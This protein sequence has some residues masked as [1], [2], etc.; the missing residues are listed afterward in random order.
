MSAD[1]F[2]DLKNDSMEA[3][4]SIENQEKRPEK[5]SEEVN[6]N[7]DKPRRHHRKSSKESSS[8]SRKR[9]INDTISTLQLGIKRR[10]M[11]LDQNEIVIESFKGPKLED[12]MKLE[13]VK[14]FME[15]NNSHNNAVIHKM[16]Y[17]CELFK[18]RWTQLCFKALHLQQKGFQVFITA[19]FYESIAQLDDETKFTNLAILEQNA[20][21]FYLPFDHNNELIKIVTIAMI[22]FIY[23]TQQLPKDQSEKSFDGISYTTWN[24]LK[25]T[26]IEIIDICFSSD[27][28]V[29]RDSMFSEYLDKKHGISLGCNQISLHDFVIHR[30][31]SVSLNFEKNWYTGNSNNNNNNN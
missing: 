30:L 27:E 1:L 18:S 29:E 24:E 2:D 19:F 5:K 20:S 13:K 28:V 10:Q 15:I 12:F 31:G 22:C 17:G 14:N 9:S 25:Q 26:A 6:N 7:K 23:I 4:S 8:E 21:T 11:V 3:I 16:I